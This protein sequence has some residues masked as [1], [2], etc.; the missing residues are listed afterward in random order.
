MSKRLSSLLRREQV[1]FLLRDRAGWETHLARARAVLGAGLQAADPTRPVL[2]LGA[3]SGLEVPWKLAPPRTTG[4]DADPWSRAWTALRHHRCPPW[5][6]DDLSGGLAALDEV[7]GRTAAKPWSGQRRP[8]AQAI[9]RLAGLLPSLQ[10]DPA[11]LRAW[12]ATYRPG[13]I[14]VANVLGQLGVVAERMVEAA[15]GW[16]PWETDPERPDPLAE[17][18]DGWTR[19]A[20]EAVL[21]VLLEGDATLVLVHDRAVIFRPDAVTLGPWEEDWTRQV[22]T[23]GRPLEA[24]DPL[25]GVDLL[26]QARRAGRR[27]QGA[28]RWLWPLA[29]GQ[30]HLVEAGVIEAAP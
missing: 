24:S 27:L 29:P 25:A 6:F 4:W 5:V 13:T 19:R 18:L 20:L 21:A 1:A 12:V 8:A 28:E 30:I 15:L 22:Q 23:G 11:A 10:P 26:A 2:I 9:S 14:L 16:A 7:A 17:A 3:G